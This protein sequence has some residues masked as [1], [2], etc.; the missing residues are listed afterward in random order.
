[1]LKRQHI[2]M[3]S[4]AFAAFAVAAIMPAVVANIGDG[5]KGA[6]AVKLQSYKYNEDAISLASQDIAEAVLKQNDQL[7]P[8]LKATQADYARTKPFLRANHQHNAAARA[9][10]AE[11][12]CMAKAIY[13][14]ARSETRSGQMAVAEVLKNRVKSKHYPNSICEVVYQGSGRKSG[15]QFSFTCDGSFTGLP[16]GKTWDKSLEMARYV[17]T[18][19]VEPITRGATH[20]HTTAV[21][22]LWSTDLRF[23]RQIGSHKFY[24]FRFKERPVTASPLLTIAPP[25]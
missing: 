5:A 9:L 3:A 14:E 1:M 11:Q 6:G 8:Y 25:I 15:C 21:N 24:R 16:S 18:H 4:A 19:D 10:K 13:F 12:L 17:M 20:Y 22:P 2:F 23:T 7:G